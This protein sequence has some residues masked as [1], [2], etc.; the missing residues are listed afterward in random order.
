MT[1]VYDLGDGTR[2]I[3]LDAGCTAC[4]KKL[5]EVVHDPSGVWRQGQIVCLDCGRTH[6]RERDRCPSI[7]PAHRCRCEFPTHGT[8][9]QHMARH[10]RGVAVWGEAA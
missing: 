9:K 7:H 1:G 3:D 4:G 8:E 5:S 2:L 10:R 6:K